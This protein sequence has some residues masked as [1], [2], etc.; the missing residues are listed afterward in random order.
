MNFTQK[1]QKVFNTDKWWGRVFFTMVIYLIYVLV[2]YI[3]IP[4]LIIFI[5]NFNFGGIIFFLS[6]FLIIPI[7]S[8]YIPSFIL[9]F[10]IL[11][12]KFLYT[13]HTIFIILIPVIF[14][15]IIISKLSFNIGGF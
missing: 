3:L 4:L 8:Y 15:L 10:F 11:N 12:K 5:Q 1:I 2:G 14:I 6:L 13:F 9:K 7:L